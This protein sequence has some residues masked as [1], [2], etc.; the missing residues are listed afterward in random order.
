MA[1]TAPTAPH[2]VVFGEESITK[3]VG[4]YANRAD[5]VA[6]RDRLAAGGIAAVLLEPGDA[7]RRASDFLSRSF[8]P[9]SR[10]IWH[11]LVRAHLLTGAIGFALGLCIWGVLRAQE[12]S[13]VASS[14]L[15]SLVFIVF[16]TTMM[17]LMAGG[18][19]ALRPDHSMVFE[20][21]RTSLRSGS[22]A[23]VAH[24]TDADGVDA[25]LR[26]LEPGSQRVT[27]TL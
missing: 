7:R 17:G 27:R 19:L 8:E 9:E 2:R 13:M 3:V 22:C 16:F 14:P 4:V 1:D 20:E 11:S 26:L 6:A 21:L 10:G 5:A 24:P 15:L 18:L 23:V 12:L 25:A